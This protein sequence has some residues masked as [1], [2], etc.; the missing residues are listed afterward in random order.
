MVLK[1][2]KGSWHGG[3]KLGSRDRRAKKFKLIFN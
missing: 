2:Q 1:N 3:T